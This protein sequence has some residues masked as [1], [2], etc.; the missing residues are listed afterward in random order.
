MMIERERRDNAPR[1]SPNK[2]HDLSNTA[3]FYYVFGMLAGVVIHPRIML[4]KRW[5]MNIDW[6]TPLNDRPELCSM[7]KSIF[8]DLEEA[9]S[10][11]IPCCLIPDKFE[12]ERPLPEDSLHGASDA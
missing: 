7:Q 3:S 12:G 8:K 4:Q 5:Q 2:V 11:K 10:I 6:D 9:V 1:S